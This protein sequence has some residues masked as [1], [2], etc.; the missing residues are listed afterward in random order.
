[1]VVGEMRM[2]GPASSARAFSL[3]DRGHTV[4]LMETFERVVGVVCALDNVEGE[5]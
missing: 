4:F 3:T 2:T 5:P 1:M